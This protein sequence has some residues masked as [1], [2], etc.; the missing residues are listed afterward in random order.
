MQSA[1]YSYYHLIDL[2]QMVALTNMNY[3]KTVSVFQS[4]QNTAS[5]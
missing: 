5:N 4:F 3:K 2:L 1:H